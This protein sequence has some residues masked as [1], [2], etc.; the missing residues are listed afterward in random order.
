MATTAGSVPSGS[1][2]PEASSVFQVACIGGRV[3]VLRLPSAFPGALAGILVRSGTAKTQA[4]ATWDA[5]VGNG[6][7]NCYATIQAPTFWII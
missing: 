5:G 6:S 3:Q 2:K 4:A 1:Q 7:L